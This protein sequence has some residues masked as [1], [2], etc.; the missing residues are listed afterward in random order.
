MT[1]K[2][3]EGLGFW[4]SK[5]NKLIYSNDPFK[6]RWRTT[7]GH[8]PYP[9]EYQDYLPSRQEG[10]VFR[11]CKCRE[12]RPEQNT[13]SKSHF[14]TQLH[15]DIQLMHCDAV[16]SKFSYLQLPKPIADYKD[17]EDDYVRRAME[18]LDPD[19]Q[20]RNSIYSFTAE[21]GLEPGFDYLLMN[22]LDNTGY[23]EHGISL[24]CGYKC[25]RSG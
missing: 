21:P 1:E 3:T 7:F 16:I 24:R 12:S 2:L 4:F 13:V 18:Y 9:R 23:M 19:I 8:L 20:E 11:W 6:D 25:I 14:L 10:R 22:Y 5:P 15:R 17:D